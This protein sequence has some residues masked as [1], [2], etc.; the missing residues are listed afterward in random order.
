MARGQAQTN[1]EGVLVDTIHY[2]SAGVML[3]DKAA[4]AFAD[5][6]GPEPGVEV[7]Q[8]KIPVEVRLRKEFKAGGGNSRAVERMQFSLV[9]RKP[10]VVLRGTDIETL[11]LAMWAELDKST[12]IVWENYLLVTIE[13]AMS[14]G[15]G[16]S[17]GLRL[18]ERT[19]WKGTTQQGY[20]MLREHSH[21][22]MG[23]GWT[24][25]PWPGAFTDKRGRVTACIPATRVNEEAMDEFRGRIRGLRSKLQDLVRPETIAATLANL[26]G[27]SLLPA[28]A[29]DTE[30]RLAGDQNL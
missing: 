18:E 16:V 9:C 14:H 1:G 28:P 23:I 4:E 24:Y 13:P 29:P 8:V 7:G 19:V 5:E 27:I 20:E 15:Y 6:V 12:A 30:P 21:D 11:R 10:S 26:S 3:T 17:E 25:R 22:R 2:E